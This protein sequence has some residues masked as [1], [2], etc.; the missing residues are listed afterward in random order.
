MNTR[1][2]VL[3]VVPPAPIVS[4]FF[5][6]IR[7]KA[8]RH[9][10]GSNEPEVLDMRE[11]KI[12]TADGI[13]AIPIPKLNPQSPIL[14]LNHFDHEIDNLEVYNAR[15]AFLANLR[16]RYSGKQ[17]I[18]IS[19]KSHIAPPEV[20]EEKKK[21]EETKEERPPRLFWEEILSTFMKIV[22]PVEQWTRLNSSRE[23]LSFIEEK[24]TFLQIPPAKTEKGLLVENHG[25][26]PLMLKKTRQVPFKYYIQK[27][28][29]GETGPNIFVL[30]HDLDDANSL[31]EKIAVLD[32]KLQKGESVHILSTLAP[33]ELQKYYS[34]DDENH[35]TQL[36]EWK[37]VLSS[38]QKGFVQ[39]NDF[40]AGLVEKAQNRVIKEC[41]YNGYLQNIQQEF[42]EQLADGQT[43]EINIIREIETRV[44]FFY[45][46]L[47][48][49]CSKEEK[50]IIYDVANDGIVNSKNREVFNCL[51]EKG[52][53]VIR[54]D[55][56][57]IMNR[58]F[59]DFILTKVTPQEVVKITKKEKG[60][61][62]WSQARVL[63]TAVILALGAFIFTTQGELIDNTLAFFTGLA[64][65][66][67]FLREI[68]GNISVPEAKLPNFFPK[69]WGSKK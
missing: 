22:Y 37:K 51:T 56:P 58:S 23:L 4:D 53:I 1:E 17:I 59:R 63:I 9:P 38:M 47:W 10:E 66:V 69:S 55:N 24:S 34:E 68:V 52:L 36:D 61:S 48:A 2:N 41:V 50:F 16:H 20:K 3:L 54:G 64:A 19:T 65:F 12:E 30:I 26:G 32:A 21:E 14:A 43:S 42:M 44:H 46:S 62:T 18:I 11:M 57:R 29:S 35:L 6:V 40:Q 13:S 39:I 27:D 7:W 33:I 25:F 67:P 5:D 60:G 49:S 45:Q 15:M 28:L 31:S 8:E